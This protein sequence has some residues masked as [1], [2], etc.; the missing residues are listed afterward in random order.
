MAVFPLPEPSNDNGTI[1]M[2]QDQDWLELTISSPVLICCQFPTL[3]TPNFPNGQMVSAGGLY[4][5]TGIGQT[6]IWA[7]TNGTCEQIKETLGRTIKINT[8][9]EKP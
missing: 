7:S 2:T 3:F 6:Q 4:K 1:T 5:A 8:A 9:M